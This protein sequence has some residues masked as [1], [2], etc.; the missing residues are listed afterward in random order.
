MKWFNNRKIGTKM[1]IGF[2]LVAL[3]SGVVGYIGMTSINSINAASESL[4]KDK[5]VPMSKI[6][7]LSTLFQ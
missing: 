6:S 1:L 3:F 5:T 7:E 4:Y 2:I